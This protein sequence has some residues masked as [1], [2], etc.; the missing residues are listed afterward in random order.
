[1]SKKDDY[2]DSILGYPR[3][4]DEFGNYSEETRY[5]EDRAR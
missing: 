3:D 5:L 4:T 1:M 2:L